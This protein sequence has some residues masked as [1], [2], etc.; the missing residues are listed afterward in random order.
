M[1]CAHHDFHDLRFTWYIYHVTA[2]SDDEL[3]AADWTVRQ[4]P[5]LVIVVSDDGIGCRWTSFVSLLELPAAGRKSVR[6][7][8][9]TQCTYMITR[10]LGVNDQA[11]SGCIVSAESGLVEI[12]P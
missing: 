7:P 11:S 4:S 5:C 6:T 8:H 9:A 12:T 10:R 1:Q 3:E 2:L